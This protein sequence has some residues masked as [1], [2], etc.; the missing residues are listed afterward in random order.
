MSCGGQW[1][2]NPTVMGSKRRALSQGAKMLRFVSYK[3]YYSCM[4][5]NELEKGRC[6]GNQLE[7]C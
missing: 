3:K 5:Q 6:Q 7:D 2:D 4:V 1:D